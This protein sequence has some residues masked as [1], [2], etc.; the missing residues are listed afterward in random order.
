[1][2]AILEVRYRLPKPRRRSSLLALA[3]RRPR[4]WQG[5]RSAFDPEKRYNLRV[6]GNQ[7]IRYYPALDKYEI[8]PVK[9]VTLE[10]LGLQRLPNGKI[11]PKWNGGEV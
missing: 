3:F 9:P 10:D 8:I 5:H 1:M 4:H 7:L 11:I 2:L 6:E